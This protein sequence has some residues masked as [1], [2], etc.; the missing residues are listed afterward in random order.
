MAGCLIANVALSH[1]LT[2]GLNR[3]P[4]SGV[5]WA[6]LKLGF[7]HILPLGYDH[8]LFVL[9]LFLLNPRLKSVLW[10]ATAFTVAHSITLGL[11]M[12]GVIDPPAHLIEPFIAL[13]IAFVAAE[14]IFTD[15]LKWWRTLV[16]FGFGLLHGCGFA[17]VLGEL[18][19]PANHFFTA[20]LSFNVGVELGQVTVILAAYLLVG[21]W[22]G[23]KSW[24][25]QRIV[26]PLSA[27]IAVV[28]LYWTIERAFL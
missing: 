13:S 10:Q 21:R 25:R 9:S 5:A 20:L 4:T 28:A 27:V 18:G 22:F 14:N 16:I 11:A 2:E 23:R 17:G 7:M 26:F 6:Y 19:L 24:Y 3:L 12:T 15:E 8:V 1:P